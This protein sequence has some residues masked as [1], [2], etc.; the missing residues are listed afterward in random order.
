MPLLAEG[1]LLDFPCDFPIKV[2]GRKAP[3]FTQT[4]TEIVL[5]H[6]PDFDPATVEMRPSRQGRYLSVTCVLRATSREQLDALYRELCDHRAVV[7]VL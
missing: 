6:A 2:M 1:S 5:R 4:V 7:M 3:G